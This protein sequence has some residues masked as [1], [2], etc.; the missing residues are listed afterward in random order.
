MILVL[1][2]SVSMLTPDVGGMPRRDALHDRL[3]HDFLQ[4]QLGSASDRLSVIVFDDSTARTIFELKPL[5]TDS[6]L[7]RYK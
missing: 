7:Q 4:N 5:S 6:G 1:D 2:N 3:V